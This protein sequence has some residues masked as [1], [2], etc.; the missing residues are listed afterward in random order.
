MHRLFATIAAIILCCFLPGHIYGQVGFSAA[1]YFGDSLTDTGNEWERDS[2]PASPPYYDGNWSN[3]LVWSEYFAADLGLSKPEPS[4]LGGPNFAWGAAQTGPGISAVPDF[5]TLNVGAQIEEFAAREVPFR[6]TD[7]VVLW[8]GHNDPYTQI[9]PAAS[10]QNYDDHFRA[11]YDLGARKFLVGN[12]AGFDVAPYNAVL[13]QATGSAKTLDGVDIAV[14]DFNGFVNSAFVNPTSFGFRH[15]LLTPACPEC[16]REAVIDPDFTVSPDG[17]VDNAD[18]YFSWDGTHPTTAAHR[19]IANLAIE[20][21]MT[22]AGPPL[23]GDLNDDWEIDVSDVNILMAGIHSGVFGSTLDFTSDNHLDLADLATWV[24]D[25]KGTYY[26]DAN[27]DGQFNRDDLVSVL[28]GGKY[29]LDAEAR[30]A[31]GDWT[32]DRR[33]DRSDIVLA[34]QDGGYEQEGFAAINAVPEPSC[35]VLLV[36][37]LLGVLILR[38]VW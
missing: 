28:Q 30:W 33:F 5:P 38:Q 8:V 22:I 9:P 12:L 6:E 17:V 19:L 32:G 4:R 20:A 7:L 16:T 13:S 18:D 10:R 35:A 21:A 15:P 27:L 31:E 3:G 14:V 11:L 24:H 1:Y 36:L 2:V 34:L 29:D 25:I 37:G 26:G 23:R